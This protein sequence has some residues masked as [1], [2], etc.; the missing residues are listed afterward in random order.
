MVSER[1]PLL[2]EF[3][4]RRLEAV[5]ARHSDLRVATN[6]LSELIAKI[7]AYDQAP[8]DAI[9]ADVV[10]MNSRVR[11]ASLSSGKEFDCT[12]VFPHRADSEAKQISVL[13]PLGVALF[14]ARVGEVLEV[15]T[16]SATTEYRV[17]EILYQPEAQG[18]FNE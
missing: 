15:V 8:S 18:N 17:L 2:S 10:T 5:V 14:G 13:A 7:Y 12:L 6:P 16:A 1:I 9:P 11:I 3:D 4:V